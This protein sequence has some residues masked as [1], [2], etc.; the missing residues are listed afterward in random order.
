MRARIME[1]LK[2]EQKQKYEEIIAETAGRAAG[3]S[4][5]RGR[6][7]LPAGDGPPKMVNVR[8]GLSDGSMTELIG[9]ELKEGDQVLVGTAQAGAGAARPSGPRLPF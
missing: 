5:S 2:P 6:V 9:G 7:F 8:T 4:A 3:A 1:L